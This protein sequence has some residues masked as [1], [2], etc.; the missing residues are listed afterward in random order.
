M[1]YEQCLHIITLRDSDQYGTDWA[2]DQRV[3]GL[4]QMGF[5]GFVV[6]IYDL[7]FHLDGQESVPLDL[8]GD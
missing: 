1:P 8:H 5:C 7:G 4:H 6:L 2:D 3:T